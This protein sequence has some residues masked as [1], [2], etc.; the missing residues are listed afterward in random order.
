MLPHFDWYAAPTEF[1][2]AA[3]WA[4]GSSIND[5]LQTGKPNA[6]STFGLN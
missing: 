2:S 1:R 5:E 3:Q 4:I 6:V